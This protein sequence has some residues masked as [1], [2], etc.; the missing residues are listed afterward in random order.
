MK[1]F[2]YEH[3]VKITRRGYAVFGILFALAFVAVCYIESVG[4]VP[5]P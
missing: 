3:E 2:D 4:T 1:K 5:A